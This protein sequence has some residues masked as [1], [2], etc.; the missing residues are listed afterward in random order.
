MS[1]FESPNG[2]TLHGLGVYPISTP[3]EGMRLYFLGSAARSG[4]S[5]TMNATSSRSHAVFTLDVETEGVRGG[6]A[7][8]GAAD[9]QLTIPTTIFT[10]GKV[11]LVDLAGSERMY[12]LSNTAANIQQAKAINLSLHYLEQVILSL[13]TPTTPSSPTSPSSPVF[14]PYRNS[15]L[16]SMLRDSLGGNC[17]SSFLLTVSSERRHFEESVATC[18]FGQRCGEIKVTVQANAEIGLSDQLRDMSLKLK[19]LEKALATSAASLEDTLQQLSNERSARVQQTSLRALTAVEKA[20]CTNCVTDLLNAA[21]QFVDSSS[22]TAGSS[23]DLIE[24]SQDRLYRTVEQMDKAVLVELSTALGGLVQSI[25]IEH[26]LAKAAANSKD[27]VREE[28]AEKESSRIREEEHLYVL[29]GNVVDLHTLPRLPAKVVTGITHGAAFIKKDRMGR[30]SVRWLQVST[31]LLQL[32]WEPL[33]RGTSKE[34]AAPL[35]T[36]SALELL[37]GDEVSFVLRTSSGARPL[38]L[39]YCH[40]TGSVETVSGFDWVHALQWLIVQNTKTAGV[41]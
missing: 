28:L 35:S 40:P 31:D 25:F 29:L 32:S 19:A 6:G 23:E 9:E 26:Q 8:A 5:T 14:I 36:F 1:L 33:G 30:E 18:R 3:E 13:R 38:H 10:S 39:T 2:I 12:K 15:V 7:C 24:S 21:R 17:R 16:T 37:G 34:H 20:N 41:D 4:G 22:G 11:H 27:R